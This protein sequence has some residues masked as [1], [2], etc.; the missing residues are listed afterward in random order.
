M[1]VRLI[2]HPVAQLARLVGLVR[3]IRPARIA[4]GKEWGL[5]VEGRG[6]TRLLDRELLNAPG[7]LRPATWATPRPITFR[8]KKA[9]VRYAQAIGLMPGESGVRLARDG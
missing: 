7:L 4:C 6:F 3:H 2:S 1:E 8:S 9:A 5:L